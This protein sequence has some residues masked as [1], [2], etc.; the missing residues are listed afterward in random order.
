MQ[1]PACCVSTHPLPSGWILKVA[2]GHCCRRLPR[3]EKKI[4]DRQRFLSRVMVF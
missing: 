1:T 2:L 3:V 4:K